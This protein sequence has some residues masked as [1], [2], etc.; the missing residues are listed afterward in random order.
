MLQKISRAANGLLNGAIAVSLASMALL[1]FG[2]VVL[3]YAFN[4]GITWSEEMSRF[5]FVWM[6]FF[7]AIAALKDKMHLGVDLVVN[8]LPK[9]LKR[10]VFVISNLCVL[11]ILWLLLDGSWKMTVLNMDSIAPAT[12]ISLSWVYGIGLVTSL[13]MAAIIIT[14]MVKVL[15]AKDKDDSFKL[16]AAVDDV[17]VEQKEIREG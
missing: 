17:S 16:I 6:V 1:V 9:T 14:N 8:L 12:G 15:F 3:R 10:I 7:G 5:L 11:F 13:A 2:N 4:S